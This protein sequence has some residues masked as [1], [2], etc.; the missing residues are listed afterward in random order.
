MKILVA[1]TFLLAKICYVIS[2]NLPSNF[3]VST[4]QALIK[5]SQEICDTAGYTTAGFSNRKGLVLTPL[6]L[7]ERDV[8]SVY[9]ADRP[10]LW[11]N[12]DVMGRMVV[13]ELPSGS[14]KPDLWVHS[15]VALDGPLQKALDSIGNVKH[16]VSPNYE[17]VKYAGQW[18]QAYPNAE[19]WG[20]PGLAARETNAAW[21]GEI[22]DGYRPPKFDGSAQESSA[23]N[24]KLWRA[25]QIESLHVDAEINPFTRKPFFNE[26]IFYHKPSKSLITTDYFWNYPES[27]V[28][29][30]QFGQDDSWEL[31]PVVDKIPI[32]SKLWKFGMDKVYLPFFDNFMVQDKTA[33][34]KI[35][36][37]ML[38][39]WDI[40][41][42]VP[43]H[44]DVIRGKDL[45]RKALTKFYSYE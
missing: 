23:L 12:I 41:M 4:R 19:L 2:Y 11:N 29:N 6:S 8:C 26:C 32:G 15:P 39:V 38:D 22:P 13:L 40:E 37:H 7:N 45:V 24:A 30:S 14:D 21:S 16:I 25:D 3:P 28:P 43:A 18:K 27:V 34:R 5:K 36:K 9:A 31:A 33:Y 20:C 44:G 10:F 1:S 35:V 42:I 17:H